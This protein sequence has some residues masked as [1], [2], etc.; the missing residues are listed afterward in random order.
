MGPWLGDLQE[1]N[2]DCILIRVK[3]LS[4]ATRNH[5]VLATGYEFEPDTIINSGE[6]LVI[7]RDP[8]VIEAA[9]SI[10]GV[11][12]PFTGRLGNDG[13]RIELSNNNIS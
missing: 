5:Q 4:D 1:I 9:Y 3:G 10:D 7:A 6:Y 11:L 13:E 8:A 2:P 12:G